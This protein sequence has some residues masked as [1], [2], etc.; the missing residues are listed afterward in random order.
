MLCTATSIAILYSPQLQ[1]SQETKNLGASSFD[2]AHC[3]ALSSMLDV[4]I[5]LAAL[6]VVLPSLVWSYWKS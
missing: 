1:I 5:F 3:V 4:T 2:T 6:F